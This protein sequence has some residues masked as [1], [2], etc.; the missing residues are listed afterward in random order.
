ML[1]E[2]RSAIRLATSLC[3]ANI[4]TVLEW[5]TVSKQ[6]R[7]TQMLE[8]LCSEGFDLASLQ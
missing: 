3:A 6:F 7:V 1:K 2:S 8:L 4:L 5:N